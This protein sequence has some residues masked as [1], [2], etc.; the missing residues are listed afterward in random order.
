MNRFKSPA[1]LLIGLILLIICLK[2]SSLRAAFAYEP[3]DLLMGLR[4]VGAA[5]DITAN[6]GP[7]TNYLNLPPSTT[8]TI[9]NL[10]T[11]Q[12]DTAF[13]GLDEVI[14]SAFSAVR[15]NVSPEYPESTLWVTAPRTDINVQSEPWLRKGPLNQGIPSSVIY[16]IGNGGRLYGNSIPD[17]PN[18]T[19][20]GVL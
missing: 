6:L 10:L 5:S 11:N 7:I 19:T 1:R 14:W 8:I 2:G 16:A 9:T 3:V 12:L 17:G 4:R 13:A 15:T 18:N 20:T